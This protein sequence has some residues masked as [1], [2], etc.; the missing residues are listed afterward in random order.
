[1]KKNILGRI[2]IIA[3]KYWIRLA[4]G[5][6]A[7]LL[8]GLVSAWPSLVFKVIVDILAQGKLFA[9]NI[10]FNPI[11]QQLKNFFNL[12]NFSFT[13]NPKQALNWIPLIL[14]VIYAFDGLLNFISVFNTRFFGVLISN[15]LRKEAH[16]KLINLS[17][18]QIRQK[19]SGD[20]I[21][22]LISDLNTVQALIA[23]VLTALVK[24]SVSAFALCLWLLF[25]D[26]KLSLIGV[27]VLPAL[28]LFL[29]KFTKKLRTLSRKGQEVI[30]I[31]AS[32][33]SETIQGADLLNLYNIQNSR[34][35]EFESKT[36]QVI[37]VWHKQLLT[38][39][40]IGPILGIIVSATIGAIIWFGLQGVLAGYKTIGDF[41]S[42]IIAV[43]LLYQPIKR[44]SRVQSQINQIIGTSERVFELIDTESK[45]QNTSN[46]IKSSN[47]NFSIEFEQA[48]FAYNNLPV[49][50]NI[51]L[52]ISEGEQIALVGGSGGGKSTIVKL[53]PRLYDLTSGNLKVKQINVKHWDLHD[54]RSLI[55]FVPQE[56]FLFSGS[57]QDNLLLAKPQ[58]SQAE[59]KK[60]LDL[61]KVDFLNSLE[62]PVDERGNNF[63]GGQRQRLAIARAFLKNSPLLILDEPTSSLDPY[64]EELIK[65]SL[66]ELKKNR[67]VLL[68]THK[69][70]SVADS[71]R[72]IYL[73]TGKII[74]DGSPKAL[75]EQKGF[76]YKFAKNDS[77]KLS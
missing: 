36:K 15:E 37:G 75:I 71:S 19:N 60:A 35:Q 20:L 54:L 42:Y 67:T 56:P 65:T 64:S 34:H 6:V 49:L 17:F 18:A 68:V 57:V 76:Y 59:L 31:L 63:S 51:N 11:P 29:T 43:V 47:N 27:V 39:A 8:A 16:K 2:L 62:E 48:F 1:M 46:P 28:F 50:H 72:I 5:F 41:S 13:I 24:D 55:S 44:L 73:Q 70:A 52:K 10:T 25:T 26:W 12:Q 38:D 40:S 22:C 53:I 4:F 33:I 14:L 66:T 30:G 7:M 3:E 61:A 32:F 23:E 74:E 45:I 69:L 58:A 21:S 77:G 9:E